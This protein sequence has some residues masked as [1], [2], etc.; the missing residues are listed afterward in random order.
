M[1]IYVFLFSVD[2]APISGIINIMITW[3]DTLEIVRGLR[4]FHP[5]LQ[6]EDI[7]LGSIFH[8]TVELPGFSDDHEL[9]NDAILESIYREW[10]EEIMIHE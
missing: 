8:W 7:S 4:K 1:Q 6:L 2:L 3:E 9:A 5:E 10:L